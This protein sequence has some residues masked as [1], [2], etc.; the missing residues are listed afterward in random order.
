MYTCELYSRLGV[1][2]S[3]GRCRLVLHKLR[4]DLTSCSIL[5]YRS[6]VTDTHNHHVSYQYKT[7]HQHAIKPMMITKIPP[8]SPI[9]TI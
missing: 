9:I 5:I 8:L 6:H 7:I 2:F 3:C 1:H 4:S